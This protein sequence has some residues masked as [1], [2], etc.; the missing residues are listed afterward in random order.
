[1]CVRVCVR[2][3]VCVC[4]CAWAWACLHE[5]VECVEAAA[6]ALGQVAATVDRGP[7]QPPPHHCGRRPHR[8]DIDLVQYAGQLRHAHRGHV[9]R[10][11]TPLEH[12]QV[13]RSAGAGLQA[14]R[15]LTYYTGYILTTTY[16]YGLYTSWKKLKE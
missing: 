16:S 13:C 1:M 9:H 7:Q 11:V 3:C 6:L 4:V 12:L 5:G 14:R 10:E 2:V 8:L 15:L